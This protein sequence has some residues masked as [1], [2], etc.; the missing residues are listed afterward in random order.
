MHSQKKIAFPIVGTD[1]LETVEFY[2]IKEDIPILIGLN[3]MGSLGTKL[4]IEQDNGP[5]SQLNIGGKSVPIVYNGSHYIMDL[6]DIGVIFGNQTQ[7]IHLSNVIMFKNLLYHI[8]THY[9]A[10]QKL[11]CHKYTFFLKVR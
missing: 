8:Q 2:V 1:T 3:F 5:G 6:E 10:L 4:K 11:A 9:H 7:R